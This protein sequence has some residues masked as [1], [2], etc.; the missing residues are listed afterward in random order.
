MKNVYNWMIAKSFSLI[1]F[2]IGAPIGLEDTI[3]EVDEDVGVK[4][5]C[6]RLNSESLM[7]EVTVIV[8]YEDNSALGKIIASMNHCCLTC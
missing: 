7:T 3:V 8:T 4:E 1:F 6:A 2:E 5:L